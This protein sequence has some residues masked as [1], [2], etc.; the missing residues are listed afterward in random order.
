MNLSVLIGSWMSQSSSASQGGASESS[1]VTPATIQPTSAQPLTTGAPVAPFMAP[2]ATGA[3]PPPSLF[4]PPA[5]PATSATPY[6]ATSHSNTSPS[7]TIN[8]PLPPQAFPA[9]SAFQAPASAPVP[10]VTDSAATQ[11]S[12]AFNSFAEPPAS[13]PL[14]V[15]TMAPPS[16]VASNMA[17]PT[18]LASPQMDSAAPPSST[19]QAPVLA[20]N[21]IGVS[22]AAGAPPMMTAPPPMAMAPPPMAGSTEAANPFR[23]GN[24][25]SNYAAPAGLQTSP[26]AASSFNDPQMNQ[27]AASSVESAFNTPPGVSRVEGSAFAPAA[28]TSSSPIQPHAS[29]PFQPPQKSPPPPSTPDSA[30]NVSGPGQTALS[31]ASS[32]SNEVQENVI[33]SQQQDA[34]T[35]VAAQPVDLN[36]PKVPISEPSGNQNSSNTPDE[37]Q[38]SAFYQQQKQKQRES[39]FSPPATLWANPEPKPDNIMLA[40]VVLQQAVAATDPSAQP[41]AFDAAG[42]QRPSEMQGGQNVALATGDPSSAQPTSMPSPTAT[43]PDP[44]PLNMNQASGLQSN[45]QHQGG[46]A[47]AAAPTL[48]QQDQSQSAFKPLQMQATPQPSASVAPPLAFAAPATATVAPPSSAVAPTSLAA[49]VNAGVPVSSNETMPD[50]ASAITNGSATQAGPIAG[51][52]QQ[53]QVNQTCF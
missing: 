11:E 22:P 44:S 14:A 2:P 1:S 45:M 16:Q 6:S 30:L 26:P 28:I 13:S 19:E 3:P 38:T 49:N 8:A 47:Q 46:I 35:N 4:T 36:I 53:Q 10:L 40:P 20:S 42:T 52:Q 32:Q 24:P 34:L 48:T 7:G 5:A 23:R 41:L 51:Y 17:G 27:P 18:T 39:T 12:A 43:Q 37:Y 29:S 15:D 9:P 31:T 25:R 50:V 21:P 33:S